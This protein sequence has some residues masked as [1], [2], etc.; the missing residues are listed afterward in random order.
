MAQFNADN[1]AQNLPDAYKKTTD[2]N[3][4]K[5]L[6]IERFAVNDF[7]KTIQELF[8]S[9]DIDTARGKTL[10]LYGGM[11]GQPRGV[12]TD[13]QYILLIKSRI[14]RNI[15]NGSYESISKSIC[16]TF[17][18]EPSQVSIIE[19][20]DPC[21]V[22]LVVLP[23]AVISRAGLTTK[24]TVSLIKTLIPVGIRLES[25]LFEGTFS[26][27]STENEYD[28]NAGFCDVE[29]GTLGGYLGIVYGEDN[30]PILPI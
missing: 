14:M 5:I 8:E 24:Q 19:K 15:S 23:L 4:Y 2:S 7:R 25:F 18:C 28:E 6:E 10:D 13:E 20:S 29:G 12:S 1:H 22:E 30:E 11:V 26:F 17:N 3:N 27:G 21:V 16:A 9:L